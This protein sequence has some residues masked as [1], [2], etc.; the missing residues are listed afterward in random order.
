MKM[1]KPILVTAVI[2]FLSA[3]VFAVVSL[4]ALFSDNMVLQ[5]GMSVPIWGWGGLN[6]PITVRFGSQ[7][8]STITGENGKWTLRLAPMPVSSQPTDMMVEGKTNSLT[9]KNVLIGEVWLASGQSN[10]FFTVS[11]CADAAKF[12]AEAK[13][14]GIRMFNV[15]T[16]ASSE[17]LDN[18]EGQWAV[19]SPQTVPSFSGTA[20]FFALELHQK[21]DVPV[22]IIHSSWGGSSAEMWIPQDILEDDRDYLPILERYQY[23]DQA[24]P[25]ILLKYNRALDAWRKAVEEARVESKP[26]PPGKPVHPFAPNKM[27][28]PSSL[29]NAMI[30]PLAPYA[31]QGTIWYQGESN[32]DRAEQYKKLFPNMI[33][34]WRRLWGQGDFPFLFVQ[35][36][37]FMPSD[38]KPGESNWA[39]L[40]EAQTQTLS[41][42]PRT[43]MAVTI[44]IGEAND[45]HPKNKQDVGKRL[46]QCAMNVAYGQDV[47]H[48]GPLYE[49]MTITDGKVRLH[50]KNVAG[51]LVSKNNEPLKGFAIAGM[52]RKFI[53]AEAAI[54]DERTIEVFD[55]NVPHPVA[56]R[57][58][59][60]INPVCNL[61]DEAGLP[62]SPFRTD[63]WAAS[64]SNAR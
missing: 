49:Y 28:K 7:T 47:P 1:R 2:L 17:P 42:V 59:W 43:A 60:A 50:F 33:R 31:I 46:M 18:V 55:K 8:V 25:N 35:L 57:Y 63:D 40:R 3:P 58:A 20:Y 56:V 14:P 15:A 29:Y 38:T 9:I 26:A 6:E 30:V 62:T 23:Q 53:W 64:T 45:I 5:Q 12:I 24:N 39:E 21:L 19:C 52:D 16:N 54:V 4:P 10:M 44:D 48:T 51:R 61:Y 34:S 41:L 13:H 32:A 11:A 22:G 37:N 36:A 27:R